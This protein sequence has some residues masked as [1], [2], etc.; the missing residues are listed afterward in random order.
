LPVF[1]TLSSNS[2]NLAFSASKKASEKCCWCCKLRRH[3]CNLKTYVEQWKVW[4][5]DFYYNNTLGSWKEFEAFFCA[6]IHSS[7]LQRSRQCWTSEERCDKSLS[8]WAVARAADW[9]T[10]AVS[11]VL[12]LRIPGAVRNLLLVYLTEQSE[13][14]FLDP[15]HSVFTMWL[16][17]FLE[18]TG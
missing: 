7:R 4:W 9:V 12:L 15:E 5:G 11:W 18:L 1:H 2:F 16:I 13:Y 6:I 3:R 8:P 10:V 17:F 14:A